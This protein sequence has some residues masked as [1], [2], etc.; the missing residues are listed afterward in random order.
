L[1]G[2]GKVKKAFLLVAVFL[3]G[4]FLLTPVNALAFR[5]SDDYVG[6][7]DHGWGDVIGEPDQYGIDWMDVEIIGGTLNVAIK[8]YY[9][10]EDHGIEGLK[11]GALFISTD[12]WNPYGE[13]PYY[14]DNASSGERWE[15]AFDLYDRTLYEIGSETGVLLSDGVMPSG[16]I[17]RNGQEVGVE[18][19]VSAAK[20]SEA[21]YIDNI[22]SFSIDLGE[23]GWNLGDLGFH[24]ASATCGND[25]IEGAAPVPE[26]ATMLLMGI[27]LLGLGVVGRKRLK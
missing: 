21:E 19:G 16:W 24:Y 25:V 8:T 9:D 3:L 15:Y 12:G 1:E 22:L 4:C 23:L 7:D 11:R 6:A 5:I 10:G 17:Y 14:G 13:A 18:D 26:P 27:G 2:E 20:G